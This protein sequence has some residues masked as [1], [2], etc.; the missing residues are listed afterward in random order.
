VIGSHRADVFLTKGMQV[1]FSAIPQLGISDHC[2]NSNS[3]GFHVLSNQGEVIFAH[4]LNTSPW[5]A[6]SCFRRD[7]FLIGNSARTDAL[8]EEVMI[9]CRNCD[10]AIRTEPKRT[11]GGARSLVR[12]LTHRGNRSLQERTGAVIITG[13]P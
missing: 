8:S 10:S 5:V 9:P 2:T 1:D 4:H 13:K 3:P 6:R 7:S 12:V 11:L